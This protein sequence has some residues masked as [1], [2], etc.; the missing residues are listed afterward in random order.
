MFYIIMSCI[1]CTRG[2]SSILSCPLWKLWPLEALWSKVLWLGP[3]L[4]V[5]WAHTV[6]DVLAFL[7]YGFMLLYKKSCLWRF[8]QGRKSFYTLGHWGYIS[9]VWWQTVASIHSCFF[10]ELHRVPLRKSYNVFT[11]LPK[12]RSIC[13]SHSHTYFQILDLW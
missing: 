5:S 12:D 8:Y 2:M 11:S 4:S 13:I 10:T 6:G 7:S 3:I 1:W 9:C